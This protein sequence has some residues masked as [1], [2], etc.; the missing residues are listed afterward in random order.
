M[1]SD[2]C[3]HIKFISLLMIVVASVSWAEQ[4][5]VQARGIAL[6]AVG[7]VESALM[8]RVRAFVEINTCIP[9]RIKSTDA[10]VQQSLYESMQKAAHAKEEGDEMLVALVAGSPDW[11]EHAVYDYEKM[12][13]SVNVRLMLEREKPEQEMAERRVEKLVMRS[14]GLLMDVPPVPNPQSAMFAYQSLEELDAIGRNFDPPSLLR[15][16]ENARARG[17][18][19]ISDCRYNMIG[20]E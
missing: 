14:V 9:V 17:L 1:K 18:R 11:A 2:G 16:Q 7:P 19:L 15:F 4:N 13:G 3:M 20:T 8:E 12:L 5:E 6:V 10:L